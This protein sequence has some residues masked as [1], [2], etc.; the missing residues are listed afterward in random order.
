MEDPAVAIKSNQKVTSRIPVVQV[1]EIDSVLKLQSGEVVILGGLM[2][3]RSRHQTSSIP[4]LDQIPII[5]ELVRG[6]R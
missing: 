2:E 4:F 5:S 1:R 6:K 3:D